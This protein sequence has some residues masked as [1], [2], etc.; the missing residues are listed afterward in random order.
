MT[1]AVPTMRRR[2][3]AG[4]TLLMVVFL[5]A[6]MI[7]AAAAVTQSVLTQGRREKEEE[8]VWR[9]QQYARAIG[10]YYRKFGKYPTKVEDLTRQT[11]GVRFLRQAYTDPMN[12]DDGSWRFIYAGPNG[13]LIGSLRQTSLLQTTLSMPG[14]GGAS[15]FGG[16]LQPLTPPGTTTGTNQAPGT[17]QAGQ[18]T[19]T[20]TTANPLESQPQPFQGAVLGGNIAGVGSKIKMPSLRIYLGGDTYQ[21]WEFIWNPTGQVAVPGQTPANPNANPTAAPNGT[22]PNSPDGQQPQQ[23][24]QTPV[25]NVPPPAQ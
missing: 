15:S 1:S 20:A 14:L 11:N 25:V 21:Q 23:N 6:T 5:V 2:K 16:G 3:Q 9:G 22:N 24:P 8:M 4:Y 17:G 19:N 7:I 18:Q 13:Q 10:L 12:K